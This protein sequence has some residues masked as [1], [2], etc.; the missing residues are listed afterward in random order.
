MFGGG[1]VGAYAAQGAD[2][3]VGALLIVELAEARSIP[4]QVSLAGAARPR[5]KGLRLLWAAATNTAQT[6]KPA[7]KR[8]CCG[9]PVRPQAVPQAVVVMADGQTQLLAFSHPP[10]LWQ[11][12][13]TLHPVVPPL[14]STAMIRRGKGGIRFRKIPSPP[15][16]PSY[17]R[18]L[19]CGVRP[20]GGQGAHDAPAGIHLQVPPGQDHLSLAVGLGR[21][22]GR[23]GLRRAAHRL[24]EVHA[25]EPGEAERKPGGKAE[26]SQRGQGLSLKGYVGF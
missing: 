6:L 16:S 10:L 12:V 19:R 3:A 8:S 1:G 20:A 7:D 5:R 4:N 23:V 9:L 13:H 22:A 2:V 14:K 11:E 21:E 15:R 26:A 25:E 17:R 24:T 18:C